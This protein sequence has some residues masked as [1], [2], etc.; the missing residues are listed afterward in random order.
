VTIRPEVCV[1]R[2]LKSWLLGFGSAARVLSP[3]SLAADLLFELDAARG[4]YEYRMDFPML[5]M[6][7]REPFSIRTRAAG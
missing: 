4:R 7:A 3:S 1:Y 2:P 6:S 5:K